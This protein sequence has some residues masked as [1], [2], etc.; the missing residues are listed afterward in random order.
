MVRSLAGAELWG[1]QL[2]MVTRVGAPVQ[3][4]GADG[5]NRG[6]RETQLTFSCVL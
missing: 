6:Y 1:A 5:G 4:G 3:G 2:G